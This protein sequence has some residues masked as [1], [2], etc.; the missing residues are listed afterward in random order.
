M[1]VWHDQ[2][3]CVGSRKDYTLINVESGRT[4]T[5]MVHDPKHQPLVLVVG[6]EY[7]LS[8]DGTSVCLRAFIIII[9][10]DFTYCL[11]FKVKVSFSLLTVPLPQDCQ[12]NGKEIHCNWVCSLSS[13]FSYCASLSFSL[14]CCAYIKV[15][16]SV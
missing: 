9:I 8:R 6:N 7:L 2:Y 16:G 15:C 3:L 10:G 11:S 13:T 4:D 1:F 5:I 12:Y 14:H